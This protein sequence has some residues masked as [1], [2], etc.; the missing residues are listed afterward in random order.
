V[1]SLQRLAVGATTALALGACGEPRTTSP[2]ETGAAPEALETVATEYRFDP[3]VLRAPRPGPVG[4]ALVNA[5]GVDHALAIEGP[6]GERV[7]AILGPG[8]RAVLRV[9]L[10][11]GS[12]KL[13]CP[14]GDHQRRGMVGRLRVA[15]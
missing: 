13:Y 6:T 14:V 8:R 5:G 7:S 10:P 3:T 12:Y 11:A 15:E 1:R 4:V 9:R 2:P